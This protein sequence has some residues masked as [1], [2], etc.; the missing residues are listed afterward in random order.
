MVLTLAGCGYYYLKGSDTDFLERALGTG[1]PGK[2]LDGDAPE[3]DN[4]SA[5]W[6]Y[7]YNLLKSPY[8]HRIP[9]DAR[10][11]EWNTA[12]S[13]LSLSGMDR[14][15]ANTYNLAGPDNMSGRTRAVAYDLRYNGSSNQTIL[16]GGVSGGIFRSTD[17]GG[18]WQWV[19][20]PQLNSVTSI[21][22][23]P[24]QGTNP[25]T[26]K[27]YN[28]T[29]YCGT[30][31]FLPTSFIT[32]PVASDL[33]FIVGW[34]MF[35]SDDD[36]LTWY[37]MTFSRGSIS[38]GNGSEET[39]D[40]AYDIINRLVVNPVNGN[41]YVS[42]FGSIVTVSESSA[43]NYNRTLTLYN[44]RD[45]GNLS[46]SNQISDI[47]CTSDG[48]T[49]F[50]GFHGDYTDPS[51]VDTSQDM[52]GIWEGKVNLS[53][54]GAITWKKISG[55]G[56]ASPTGWPAPG[57]YGRIVLSLA[58]SNPH[59]L[60]ALAAN[61]ADG[62]LDAP[63]GPRPEADLFRYND[64]T[65][66]WTDLSDNLPKTDSSDRGAF[67]VQNGYDMAIAVSPVDSMT[68]YIGGT[69]AY[70]STDGFTSLLHTTLINGYGRSSFNEFGYDFEIGHPDIHGFTFRP[71]SD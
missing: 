64:S 25:I 23:D 51:N 61:G 13:F 6:L 3:A 41:L 18:T 44:T 32:G 20:T 10:M 56:A 62:R 33:S 49:L 57:R 8:T 16:T 14:L 69:N 46:T 59:L 11:K 45:N 4:P 15:S 54:G 68:V 35:Q 30:G 22:Q 26:G 70:R 50:A 31:E 67:Q 12:F 66:T 52:E 27:P 65:G 19:S 28:D 63:G 29:W 53:G 47:V 39:F 38:Q 9:P 48:T 2:D 58:P 43:G 1:N 24:R 71:G 40:N 21:V 37:S 5:V 60:Y 36:G 34:G 42:R 7:E 17:G 55:K